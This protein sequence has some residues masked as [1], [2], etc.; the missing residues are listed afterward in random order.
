MWVVPRLPPTPA[1][2]FVNFPS[3]PR[4][5]KSTNFPELCWAGDNSTR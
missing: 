4:I 5:N 1:H 3:R 2:Y